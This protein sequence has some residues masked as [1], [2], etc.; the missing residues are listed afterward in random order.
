MFEL[1]IYIY[2]YDEVTDVIYVRVC[3]CGRLRA[4][5]CKF[6]LF[7]NVGVGFNLPM[8]NATILAFSCNTIDHLQ[9]VDLSYEIRAILQ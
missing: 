5:L 9:S 6:I 1:Y 2:I 8:G 3:G 7:L 4:V